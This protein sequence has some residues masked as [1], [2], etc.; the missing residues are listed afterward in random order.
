MDLKIILKTAPSMLKCMLG[1]STPLRVT[2]CITYRCNLDCSYCKRHNIDQNELKT[3]EIKR[4]I[5]SFKAYGTRFWGFNGGE[6][7]MRDDLPE[8]IEHV[9]GCGMYVSVATNG[10]LVKENIEG[11]KDVDMLTFS[12]DGPKHIHDRLR[13]NSFDAMIEGLNAASDAKINTSIMTVI[14]KS[15]IEHLD[16]ILNLAKETG[17]RS[18]FQP[19]RIQKEDANEDARKHYPKEEQMQEA[20]EHLLNRKKQRWPVASTSKYLDTIKNTWPDKAPILKCWAGRSYA[21]IT[22]EGKLTHCCDTLT[23]G[24][25][26]DTSV[27][28]ASAFK[29]LN[30]IKC[31]ECFS[32]IPCETNIILENPTHA[33]SFM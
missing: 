3:D 26:Q 10:T 6:A 27:D 20:M 8:L 30:T 24:D 28:G 5:D 19:I 18:L 9:K 15:N 21:F 29:R 33:F 7:L 22:P 31:K 12:I 32:A 4:L 11:L 14:S 17:S 1:A 25:T 16:D 23:R 13:S 2:Q